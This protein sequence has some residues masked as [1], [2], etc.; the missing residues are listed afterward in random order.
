MYSGR[1]FNVLEFMPCLLKKMQTPR[2]SRSESQENRR[3]ILAEW[4]FVQS[5][6]AAFQK[7]LTSLTLP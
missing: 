5:F 2:V 6:Y 7:I 3:K 1:L 4:P